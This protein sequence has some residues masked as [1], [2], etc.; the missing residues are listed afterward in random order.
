ML[1][2][3]QFAQRGIIRCAAKT[4]QTSRRA[5]PPRGEIRTKATAATKN[6]ISNL[7]FRLTM[8]LVSAAEWMNM[9]TSAV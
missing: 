5:A 9:L 8:S 2:E 6:T 3:A 7:N 4:S 1:R